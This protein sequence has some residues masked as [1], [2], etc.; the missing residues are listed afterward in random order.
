MY[1]ENPKTKGSG[2]L[3]A[4]PQTG[5][6]PVRCADCFF[7]SGRS[8]LEPLDKNL[9]N[10]PT[11]EQAYGL[12]VRMNDGN[13]SNVDRD[14]VVGAALQYDHAFFNTSIPKDLAGFRRPVVLTANPGKM[15]DDRFHHPA[16]NI[17]F[18]IMFVRARVNTWNLELVEQIID[19]WT[20]HDVPVVL[21][22]MA[23][24]R[25]D[26]PEAYRS[27]YTFRQRTLNSYWVLTDEAHKRIVNTLKLDNP[28]VLTCGKD[29]HTYSCR[30]CGVCLR[31]YF[32]TAARLKGTIR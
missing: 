21:T 22:F 27:S 18:N 11:R 20:A 23:Y 15:T 17:A 26:I 16:G 29:N 4:I 6:C 10:V 31:E 25:Q 2:I 8:Y 14:L 3:C 30:E 13:D 12:V 32:A 24:Y 7:Q 1:I 28:R 19:E 5:E 9:P